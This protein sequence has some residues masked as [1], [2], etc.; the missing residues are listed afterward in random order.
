MRTQN[1]AALRHEIE[2]RVATDYNVRP[3]YDPCVARNGDQQ[4]SGYVSPVEL[5]RMTL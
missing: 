1:K 5:Q 4:L 3:K 2:R